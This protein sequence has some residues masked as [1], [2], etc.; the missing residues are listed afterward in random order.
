MNYLFR[1][2]G[3][4]LSLVVFTLLSI[5]LSAQSSKP[6]VIIVMTD[7]QGYG[8]LSRHG[9]PILKTPNLDKLADESIRFVD[10][11][12]APMCTPTRGQLMTGI[13]AARNGAINVSSGRS[14]LRPELKTMADIFKSNGYKTGIFG[15][16]HLGDNYPFRPVDRGFDEAIWF[17]SS[18]IGSVPDFWGNVYFDDTY[19]HNTKRKKFKGYCTDIFFDE[20]IRFMKESV[21]SGKP[22]F[23][24]IPTNTP[25]GPLISKEEDKKA[26]EAAFDKADFVGKNP[27]M[28]EDLS[29]YLGM[30]RNID[31]NMEKLMAFLEAEKLR[32]NTIVIF[33]TD[34][35]STFGSQYFNAGMRGKKTQ[36]WEGGHRVPFFISW[37]KGELSSPRD[38]DGLTQV[39]DVLPT[40]VDLCQLNSES[41]FDGINLSDALRGKKDLDDERILVINYSR[42]PFGFNYPSPFSKSLL[43]RDQ[44][45]VLWKK[46]RLL[47]DRELYNLEKDPLQK[48]NVFKHHPKVV[49]K[50]RSHLYSWWDDVEDKAN[51]VQRI[52]IGHNAENP[53]MITAC[54]WLDVFVD[55]QGQVAKGT[56]KYGYWMLDVA[57]AGDYEIELSR[58]PKEIGVP[59]NGKPKT[60]RSINGQIE[61]GTALAIKTARIVIANS[62]NS[63]VL[64]GDNSGYKSIRRLVGQDA[65]S[66]KFNVRLTTGPIALHTFFGEQNEILCSSYYVY[67]R[68]K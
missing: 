39:Q 12:V 14:L 42:T 7:D 36:L 27:K 58:W 23:T 4:I 65:V 26:I 24:Y 37:P 21:K 45:A 16:W 15:K 44:A 6:N 64:N 18:H 60:S 55:Q 61:S 34:N 11:H 29:N 19:I 48:I 52:I 62:E 46:W 41:K 66:V 5:N 35:G 30:V 33:L 54:E 2:L 17:P 49:N 47:N 53:M 8:E 32:E 31:S 10:F 68:R 40:L 9:N 38:L 57:E 56:K 63:N 25:H 22:F 43:S 50:M 51:E 59:I 28:K 20:S 67:I 3:T 13:D 1:K